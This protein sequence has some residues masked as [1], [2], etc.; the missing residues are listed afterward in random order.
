MPLYNKHGLTA[1][2]WIR[3]Q[4]RALADGSDHPVLFQ[5]DEFLRLVEGGLANI[6]SAGIEVDVDLEPAQLAPFID[7]L[8]LIS[9][10]FT[11]FK[12]G[13]GF[14][15]ARLLRER[16][17]FTAELRASGDILPDQILFLLRVGF[18]TFELPD[19]F[20]THRVREALERYSVWFQSAVD[21]STPVH[22]LRQSSKL[23]A[24]E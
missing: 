4:D 23:E 1:D 24:A 7:R 16:C 14:T 19:H 2:P 15:L 11:S 13:R 6:K 3:D 10:R 21:S 22:V 17:G 12:D 18:S 5:F 8:G 20:P 9:V